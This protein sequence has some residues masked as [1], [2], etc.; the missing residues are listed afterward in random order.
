MNRP[1]AINLAEAATLASLRAHFLGTSTTSTPI[2]GMI[3]WAA[4]AVASLLTTPLSTALVVTFGSGMIF[5]LAMLIDR[6]RGRNLTAGGTD[7]PLTKLFLTSVFIIAIMW[8]VMFFA[9]DRSGDANFVVLGGALLMGLI[10]IPYGWAAADPSGLQHA[11][12]R[13]I[14]SCAAFLLCPA[15]YT[16]TAIA[17]VVPGAYVF[18]LVRMRRPG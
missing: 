1:E 10:W 16:A 4:V 5:P 17:V 13:A 18:S 6:L 2:A 14:G 8:P 7:N 11:L 3:F 15:P 9:A 12:G